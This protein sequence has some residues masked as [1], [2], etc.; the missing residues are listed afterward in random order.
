M[1]KSRDAIESLR[2]QLSRLP[3]T[4]ASLPDTLR[5]TRTSFVS[6]LLD[7]GLASGLNMAVSGQSMSQ[8]KLI[9]ILAANCNVTFYRS[10]VQILFKH[11]SLNFHVVINFILFHG[12]RLTATRQIYA[13]H[14]AGGIVWKFGSKLGQASF[15]KIKSHLIK[16]SHHATKGRRIVLGLGAHCS[17]AVGF[18]KLWVSIIFCH[19]QDL[20]F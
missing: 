4:K 1:L 13:K 18:L 11:I 16:S 7:K 9:V 17:A 6:L 15:Q 8:Q 20:V 2:I 19:F 3:Q 5:L 12:R 14:K 10:H